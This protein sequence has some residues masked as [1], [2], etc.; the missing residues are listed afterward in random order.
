MAVNN[1]GWVTLSNSIHMLKGSLKY[2]GVCL[3]NPGCSP[4]ASVW[5]AVFV[6]SVWLQVFL[7]AV[8]SLCPGC[9]A[10]ITWAERYAPSSTQQPDLTL[11]SDLC[12]GTWQRFSTVWI[13]LLVK[14]ASQSLKITLS[15]KGLGFVRSCKKCAF[16]IDSEFWWFPWKSVFQGENLSLKFEK[17][18]Q[19]LTTVFELKLLLLRLILHELCLFYVMVINHSILCD[20]PPPP[21]RVTS[22]E[23]PASSSAGCLWPPCPPL[24]TDIV[25][26]TIIIFTF[27]DVIPPPAW[28]PFPKT[29][30]PLVSLWCSRS[31][32]DGSSAHGANELLVR[33]AV[34][35]LRVREEGCW[36]GLLVTALISFTLSP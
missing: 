30:S 24:R 2:G 4:V 16:H 18:K 7:L 17:L 28:T 27:W 26:I 25:I 11:T 12:T 15:R 1:C 3:W 20:A 33:R 14:P 31:S 19:Y 22:S 9:T 36:S 23:D 35:Q 29:P 5:L 21:L 8:P 10:G 34:D 13:C 32:G 6:P